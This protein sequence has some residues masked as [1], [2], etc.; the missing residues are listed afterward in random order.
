MMVKEQEERLDEIL[1]LQE[2][3]VS[4][5]LD[6]WKNFSNAGTVPFWIIVL[7][8]VVPLVLIYFKIDRTKAFQIGFYGFNIHTWFTYSDAIAM[9]TGYVYY[10]FQA[11]PIMPVNFALDASLVPVT[12]MLVYQ[13][14][15]N[16][17][18]N[19][20]LYG[21]VTSAVFSF[22]VKPVMVVWD[23]IQLDNGMNYFYLF[24]NYLA[25][26]LLAIVLTKVFIYF[27]TSS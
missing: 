9:R 12:F 21:I 3:V 16:N 7:M 23:L 24:L 18:K 10:P 13:W 26:L 4:M 25:I 22:V 19:V 17:D 11:I 8:L 14:C 6:Y 2:K 5:W 15:I 20:L 27:K 1:T